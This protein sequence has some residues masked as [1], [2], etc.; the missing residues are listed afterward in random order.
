MVKNLSKNTIVVRDLKRASTFL[1]L[2]LGLHWLKNPPALL[3]RTRFGIH[4]LFLKAAI[5]VVVLDNRLRVVKLKSNLV[6]NR[7]FFWN[8][9]YELVMELPKGALRASRTGL[10]DQLALN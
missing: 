6:P 7:F 1:E 8:P 10:G 2:L 3:F 5:D 4:T 9:K